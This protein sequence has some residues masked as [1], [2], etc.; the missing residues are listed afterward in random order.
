[1]YTPLNILIGTKKRFKVRRN[2][3]YVKFGLSYNKCM[4]WLSRQR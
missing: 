4:G 1:M 3:V 2:Q